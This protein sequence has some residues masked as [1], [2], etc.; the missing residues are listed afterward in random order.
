VGRRV[1]PPGGELGLVDLLLQQQ[2]SGIGKRG[3][4]R[5]VEDRHCSHVIDPAFPAARPIDESLARFM[6]YYSL[7]GWTTAASSRSFDTIHT[8]EPGCSDILVYPSCW[9]RLWSWR[10]FDR[11]LDV[12]F[13]KGFKE[14]DCRFSALRNG[15]PRPT[16]WNYEL[17]RTGRA[18]DPAKRGIIQHFLASR[19]S[20]HPT[21][22]SAILTAR[23]LV[24]Y[25]VS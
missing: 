22:H 6:I 9:H 18:P 7:D 24:L 12:Q 16:E 20:D 3:S 4:E 10:Y 19:S 11:Q 25:R 17:R 23:G 14:L 15:L 1:Y 13:H 8:L 21:P 5:M 2:R